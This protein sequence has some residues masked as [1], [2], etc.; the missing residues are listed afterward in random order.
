MNPLKEMLSNF[1]A[2]LLRLATLDRT[3][4]TGFDQMEGYAGDAA[5]PDDQRSVK[6]LQ[7]YGLRSRPPRGSQIMLLGP[8]GATSQKVYVASEAPGTGP[9]DQ[10]EGEVELYAKPGQR[11]ILDKDGQ[12]TLTTKGATIRID[13]DGNVLISAEGAHETRVNGGGA[14]VATVGSEVD[15]GYLSKTM[16]MGGIA[17]LYWTDPDQTVST[18]VPDHPDKLH[19][20]GRVTSGSARFKAPAP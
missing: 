3:D 9:A 6:R 13:T 16:G 11:V 10:A 4:A 15:C 20:I 2:A 7:H 5:D 12:I 1:G 8:G 18:V 14:A 17:T 19:L